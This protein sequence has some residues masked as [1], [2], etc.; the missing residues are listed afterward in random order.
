MRTAGVLCPHS[1]NS[2]AWTLNGEE[3][4]RI[5]QLEYVYENTRDLSQR[6]S[7]GATGLEVARLVTM[8]RS[9]GERQ[10]WDLYSS[11]TL[12]LDEVH[13]EASPQFQQS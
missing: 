1:L 10:V 11:Q 2:P 13:S 8:T 5:T 4:R 6:Q 7:G 9:V 12:A 3:A